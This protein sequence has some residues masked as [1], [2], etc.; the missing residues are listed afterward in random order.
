MKIKKKKITKITIIY[1]NSLLKYMTL[2]YFE[3]I[4][5]FLI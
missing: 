3:K 5:V 2:I 4:V 1:Y